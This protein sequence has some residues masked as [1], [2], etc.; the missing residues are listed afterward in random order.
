M[1]GEAAR[2]DGPGTPM[3]GQP[4]N[5]PPSSWR[6]AAGTSEEPDGRDTRRS[7]N[8]PRE[9]GNKSNAQGGTAMICPRCRS[10]SVETVKVA[11]GGAW[12]VHQCTCCWY[13][14]RNTEPAARTVPERFPEEFRLTRQ[15]ITD[16]P[17]LPA[18]PPLA[19]PVHADAQG[20]GDER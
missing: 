19:R 12:Q 17:E 9:P 18:V 10:K 4:G 20:A 15:A 6:T 3:R 13:G 5:R 2:H 7:R 1:A 16:A 8:R 14:W 11:P